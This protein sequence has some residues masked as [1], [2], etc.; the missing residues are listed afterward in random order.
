MHAIVDH[1]DQD[2]ART[3]E[4]AEARESQTNSLLQAHVGIEPQN[5]IEVPHIAGGRR[6]QI[7]DS[8]QI[9]HACIDLAAQLEQ[10]MP[11]RPVAPQSGRL[12][13]KHGAHMAGAQIIDQVLETGTLYSPL[14][15]R[16]RSSLITFTL[17]NPQRRATST[18]SYCRRWLSS[19]SWTCA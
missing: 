14:A 11:V 12:Q 15:V 1:Q 7:V 19:L 4:F 16:P 8:V 13:A 2:L 17:R 18:S 5:I 3:A 6:S 9:D 10:P